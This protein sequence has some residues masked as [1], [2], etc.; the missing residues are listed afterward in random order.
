MICMLHDTTT[1]HFSKRGW[2]FS[3][4]AL[5]ATTISGIEAKCRTDT[6]SGPSQ[7]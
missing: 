6:M 3:G 5:S 4:T 7:M 1:A 2:T